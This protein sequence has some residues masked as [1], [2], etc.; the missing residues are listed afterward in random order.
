M[1]EEGGKDWAQTLFIQVQV[2]DGEVATKRLEIQYIAS[3]AAA[4]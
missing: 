2:Q 1:W 3:K 4:K